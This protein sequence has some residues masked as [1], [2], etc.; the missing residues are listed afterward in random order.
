M[1]QGQMENLLHY[2]Q[3]VN[4]RHGTSPAPQVWQQLLPE[5]GASLPLAWVVTRPGSATVFAEDSRLEDEIGTQLVYDGRTVI[6]IHPLA[7]G[8]FSEETVIHSG[9]IRFSASY[10]TVF[11]EPEPGGPFFGWIPDAKTLMLKLHLD[12]PLPGIPGDRRLSARTIEKCVSLS[13][14][15]PKAI[16]EDPMG[17]D[18]EIVREAFGITRGD[19]G[20]IL[21]LL[22]AT[23]LI[24]VFSLYSKDRANPERDPIIVNR[25]TEMYGS[26]SSGAAKQFGTLFAR[27]LIYSLIAGFRAGLSLEMHAQ[28]TLISPGEDN[29]ID[30]VY[31]RDIEG[32][33][34]FNGFRV[35]R[36]LEPLLPDSEAV[37]D[38][39]SDAP[40]Q[41]FYNRNVDHDLGRIFTGALNA[42]ETSGYFGA[43]ERRL[44]VRSIRQTVRAAAKEGQLTEIDR[45]GRYLPFSRA[46]WGNG[47]R[48][49]HYFSTRYR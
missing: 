12:E 38:S 44:A 47:L 25:L 49:G 8:K 20:V 40:I 36:G 32:A 5:S 3:Q 41:A 29:I 27:P 28:N 37:L 15:M 4:D 13:R 18:L 26:D 46:P 23:G 7:E 17:K 42:L 31:F 19:C 48:P 30:R 9:H 24:P 45:P 35:E 14:V 1:K 6:P 39:Y 2:E 34:L 22:P 33:I 11:Y 16:A 10:R 43:S 21:R